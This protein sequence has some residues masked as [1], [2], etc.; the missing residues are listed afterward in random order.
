MTK[1][2]CSCRILCS[3]RT[4]FWVFRVRF[5]KCNIKLSLFVLKRFNVLMHSCIRAK[6]LPREVKILSILSLSRHKA[7]A[8]RILRLTVVF[9]NILSTH[10]HLS[11]W[12]QIRAY[13]I[14]FS[15]IRNK[16]NGV[17]IIPHYPG[18]ILSTET[19]LQMFQFTHSKLHFHLM[20]WNMNHMSYFLI[21]KLRINKTQT[22][23][24]WGPVPSVM[25]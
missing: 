6:Q 15:H 25:T 21:I 9:Q 16:D 22:A 23:L 13:I 14:C 7:E 10:N 2:G 3:S 18:L 20:T 19:K 24:L 17:L 11:E 1:K 4:G 5:H 12:M 8:T